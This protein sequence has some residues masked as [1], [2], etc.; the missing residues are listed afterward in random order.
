MTAPSLPLCVD[1]R[2]EGFVILDRIAASRGLRINFP[3]MTKIDDYRGQ[4]TAIKHLKS[5]IAKM[6]DNVSDRLCN[7]MASVLTDYVCIPTTC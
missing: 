6:V 5:E 4:Q 2:I 7:D 3:D 1:Q